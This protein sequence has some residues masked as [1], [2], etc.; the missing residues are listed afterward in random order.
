MDVCVEIDFA[1]PKKESS[2]PKEL[3]TSLS[4][5]A[6]HR[7]P[8]VIVRYAALS[9][10]WNSTGA[11]GNGT[12]VRR[13]VSPAEDSSELGIPMVWASVRQS[14]TKPNRINQAPRK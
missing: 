9:V 2:T 5:G 3:K 4:R 7:G 14:P 10:N 6:L 12:E 8:W 13:D 11:Q 1:V